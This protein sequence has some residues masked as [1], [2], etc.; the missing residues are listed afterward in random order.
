MAISAS[1]VAEDTARMVNCLYN[2]VGLRFALFALDENLTIERKMAEVF[3]KI[4]YLYF[5]LDSWGFN[6]PANGKKIFLH[7]S[8]FDDL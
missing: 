6:H 4:L 2:F 3:S 8:L 5:P 7:R 1:D